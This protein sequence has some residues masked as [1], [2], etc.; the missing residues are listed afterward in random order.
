MKTNVQQLK[1]EN[2]YLESVNELYNQFSS[3][4]ILAI[5]SLVF[6]Y[7]KICDSNLAIE[8]QQDAFLSLL[9]SHVNDC[10]DMKVLYAHTVQPDE[11]ELPEELL[12]ISSSSNS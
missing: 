3:A 7:E 6:K 4:A 11:E 12:A 2:Q 9:Y 10:M 1:E 8:E 5:K